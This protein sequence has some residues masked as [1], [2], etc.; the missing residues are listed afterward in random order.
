MDLPEK[1][2][3]NLV[4]IDTSSRFLLSLIN[5][6][7]DMSKAE[8][9]KIELHPEPYP[10]EE[11]ANYVDSIIAPL[12]E[13][14]NQTFLFEPEEMLTDVVPLLDK[15]RINQII[16]NLLSNAV[17]YTPEGGTIRYRV[18]EKK[19]DENHMSMHMD[20]IDNGIGM[21]S[22]FQ[23]VLFDPFTQENRHDVDEMRG[24]GLGLA[25]TKRMVDA[26]DGRIDVDSEPGKGTTFHLDISVECVP[27]DIAEEGRAAGNDMIENLDG[28]HILL[29]EDHPLNQ[30][31]ATAIL[32]EQ[33]AIVTVADDGEAGIRA[34]LDSAIGYFDCI[35]MDIHMPIMDGY[36]AT[37]KIRALKRADA[38]S[39]PIIAM[40]A[41]AFVDDIQECLDAGMN[42]H[43]AKP[44][45]PNALCAE[46]CEMILNKE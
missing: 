7:L 37:R 26:M 44:V 41:D 42:G 33:Q 38:K 20:I 29:C 12:C 11:F 45:D 43:I 5:D 28:R 6:V 24:S 19:L 9:G 31:I 39:V 2:K 40:T 16:F 17:K 36:E 8:S 35:L 23:N 25:I 14:R 18:V 30:E 3:E 4:K 27:S 15:L 46:L 1:A 34:F 13:E 21:S 10:V 22:E 32:E